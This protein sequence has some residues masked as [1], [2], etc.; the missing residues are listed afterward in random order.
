MPKKGTPR[1][2]ACRRLYTIWPRMFLRLNASAC[3]SIYA[4]NTRRHLLGQKKR[5]QYVMQAE[6]KNKKRTCRYW[7]CVFVHLRASPPTGL[8]LAVAPGKSSTEPG[9]VEV[10]ETSSNTTDLKNFRSWARHFLSDS[11]ETIDGWLAR[12]R[13][14][15]RACS[16]S[17]SDRDDARGVEQ[18]RRVRMCDDEVKAVWFSLVAHSRWGH[19]R[20]IR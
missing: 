8:Q 2:S 17:E 4:R 14:F 3:V 15:S 19:K 11:H 6:H 7:P 10:H 20:A 18:K 9:K 13:G 12:V 1:D 16:Q 5:K